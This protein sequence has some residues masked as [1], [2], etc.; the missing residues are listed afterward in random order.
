MGLTRVPSAKTLWPHLAMQSTGHAR[1]FVEQVAALAGALMRCG[2]PE[3]LGYLVKELSNVLSAAKPRAVQL[4]GI[5]FHGL[6][7]DADA[8]HNSGRAMG[9]DQVASSKSLA[10]GAT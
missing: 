1:R 7:G 2:R 8:P 4:A 5:P 3:D 9:F 6:T 10:N